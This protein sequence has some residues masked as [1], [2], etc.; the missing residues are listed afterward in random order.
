[1]LHPV[2]FADSQ[3]CLTSTRING[4]LPTGERKAQWCTQ[5]STNT[6]EPTI[7]GKAGR[8][9]ILVDRCHRCFYE[10]R[11]KVHKR[12]SFRVEAENLLPSAWQ[13]RPKRN[14]AQP[15]HCRQNSRFSIPE[16][17]QLTRVQ[18]FTVLMPLVDYIK[19][20]E[21]IQFAPRC[22]IMFAASTPPWFYGWT[23]HARRRF[24]RGSDSEKPLSQRL[25][26][27][28]SETVQWSFTAQ[29]GSPFWSVSITLRRIVPY[30]RHVVCIAV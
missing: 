2:S 16:W 30:N 17:V 22:S 19:C 20:W 21:G 8:Y 18:L 1:M 25:H 7:E 5:T 10:T 29:S 12:V 4:Y 3:V 14:D 9:A 6:L 28:K 26:T 15:K 27:T 11:T 24:S 13:R 23:L